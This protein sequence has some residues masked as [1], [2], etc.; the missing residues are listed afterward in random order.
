MKNALNDLPNVIC[1]ISRSVTA[2][3]LITKTAV[4]QTG[5]YNNHFN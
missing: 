2:I 1:V 5:H 3:D 4:S